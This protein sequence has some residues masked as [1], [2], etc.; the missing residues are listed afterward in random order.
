MKVQTIL[1]ALP[2]VCHVVAVCAQSVRGLDAL[3]MPFL[4]R[5]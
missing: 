5:L 1:L 3:G 4:G 2:S